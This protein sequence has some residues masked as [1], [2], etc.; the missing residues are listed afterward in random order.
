VEKTE[1]SIRADCRYF[2]GEKPCRFHK[3]EG[4]KCSACPYFSPAGEKILIIK[5]GAMGDIL[6]TTPILTGLKEKYPD[7]RITWI[8]GRGLSQL[9]SNIDIL[10][11]VLE[12]STESSAYISAVEFD[13]VLSLDPS[14]EGGALAEN[15]KS[16]IKKGFGVDSSGKLYPFDK[17]SK[18]WYLTGIFDGL[19]K[20]N[21][22]TY[23]SF[24]SQIAQIPSE[25]YE[26]ILNLTDKEKAFG[27]KFLEDKHIPKGKP[28]VGL[29]TGAGGRWKLK[30][31]TREG[32]LELAKL[33]E[34]NL[35]ASVLIF[36][37]PLE[38]ERNDWLMKNVSGDIFNTG[39]NNTP[40]EFLSLLD[41]CDAVVTG[42]TFAMHGAAG[43]KKKTIALFGPTSSSEIE[44]YGRGIKITA[45]MDCLCC[46]KEDC[47]KKPNCM[48][49]IK[50]QAVYEAVKKTL[51]SS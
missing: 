49:L 5:L 26:I 8:T 39:T 40:R 21:T 37:G 27:R 9:L 35:H 41:L 47:S 44:L 25:N 16:K 38:K 15:T 1:Y 43:L 3:E 13:I 4:V 18:E 20:K 10:D 48:E 36:G 2:T 14:I 24:A 11:L 28:I 45:P 42:D 31:W 22:R 29:N 12:V 33:I 6:R 34:R 30:K 51:Q 32:F 7:A 19:K 50:P 17:D 23:Q 46:Y